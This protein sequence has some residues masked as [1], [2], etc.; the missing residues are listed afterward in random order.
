MREPHVAIRIQDCQHDFMVQT[1]GKPMDDCSLCGGSGRVA[2]IVA[3]ADGPLA[4]VAIQV[5]DEVI[6]LDA[7]FDG[8]VRGTLD[9]LGDFVDR[10]TRRLEP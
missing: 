3:I 6:P 5:D 8:Y 9:T 4:N 2:R 7:L 1:G 10:W